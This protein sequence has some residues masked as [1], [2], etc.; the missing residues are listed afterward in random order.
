MRLSQLCAVLSLTLVLAAC[1]GEQSTPIA[2]ASHSAL[3]ASQ[4]APVQASVVSF[5]GP[6]ANYS[7]SK[8]AD[9]YVVTD[10]TGKEA[11]RT[12]AA[13]ARL[14]F[15]DISL[16]FDIDGIPGQAYRLYRAAFARTPDVGGLGFWLGVLD[17]GYSLEAAANGFVDSQEYKTLYAS[18]T[19]NSDI[20]SKY[21]LNVLE[22]KGDAGG[23]AFWSGI[24]DRKDGT[25][26]GVLV[27]FSESP[28]N[29]SGTASLVQNG[30]VYQE[31]GVSYSE[32]VHSFPLRAALRQ[33][34]LTAATD[35]LSLTGSCNGY[36][37]FNRI[38]PYAG[39]IEGKSVTVAQTNVSVGLTNCSPTSLAWST[40]DFYDSA[41]NLTGH[42]EPGTE[43]DVTSGGARSLPV[44]AKVGD[45]GVYAI[46]A[47]YLDATK[48]GTAGT[49]TLSYS[50]EADGSST[51]SAI[52]RLTAVHVSGTGVLNLTRVAS[53]RVH[54][55]GLVQPL[56]VEETYAS[57]IKL[58][59]T[60]TPANAQPAKLI[61]NDTLT[62]TGTVSQNGQTLTVNYTG[63]LYDP[64]AADFKGKQFDSSIGRG[65]FSFQL[66]AGQVIA[67]W[68]QGMLGMKVGGKRT[69]LIPSSMGYGTSGAGA[70]IPG[71]AALV[72]E[73]E[74]LSAK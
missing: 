64:S 59:Y 11:A 12:V 56:G 67:G 70:S 73:V 46:Q 27:G 53:Y 68:D 50:V 60:Q 30:I 42:Y 47:L 54:I 21:Y 41:D 72:F 49:R 19:S 16:S 22:R 25:P 55:N 31:D 13:T 51:T 9:G 34:S 28:E 7:F 61:I 29:K 15:T 14:R 35:Y 44:T 71:N 5:V 66:G 48:Q 10:N 26:A 8:T 69:L 18:A 37:A 4:G 57:G 63:W 32:S 74:L 24:L 65:P 43:Y 2:S 23:L 3:R 58:T 40:Y 39:T 36:A 20:V 45:K 52:L 17:K 38:A 33:R 6:L 62:G 1:G